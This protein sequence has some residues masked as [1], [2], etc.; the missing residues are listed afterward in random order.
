MGSICRREENF[1][2]TL[3]E[4]IGFQTARCA[5]RSAV[6]PDAHYRAK[7]Y[8]GPVRVEKLRE[9]MIQRDLR[10]AEMREKPCRGNG[11]FRVPLNDA[12]DPPFV[13]LI[14]RTAAFHWACGFCTNRKAI[15]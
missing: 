7:I 1:M 10:E 9:A 3:P 4:A 8:L 2:T 6:Q 12:K 14:C 11:I 13:L 5:I 15:R